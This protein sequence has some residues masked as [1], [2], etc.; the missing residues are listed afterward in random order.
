MQN[1]TQQRVEGLT[2]R[3]KTS[4]VVPQEDTLYPRG[5]IAGLPEDFESRRERFAEL[6][7]LEPGWTLELRKRR[8]AS[9][10][11]AVFYSPEG[12][13]LWPFPLISSVLNHLLSESSS[14][15]R[16]MPVPI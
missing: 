10:V 12:D 5:S 13:L 7:A 3:E 6:D 1:R 11:E 15:L 14:G 8:S 9:A 4:K 2:T 16:L